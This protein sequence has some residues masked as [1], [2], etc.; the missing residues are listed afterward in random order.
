MKL[1]GWTGALA[2][3]VSLSALALFGVSERRAVANSTQA[4]Q[5]IRAERIELV[6]ARGNVR[7]RLNTE[8]D[9]EVVL[10]L[11][12]ANGEIRAKLGASDAGSA[13]VLLN[14]AT[15]PGVHI[16]ATGSETALKLIDGNQR[17]ILE[18]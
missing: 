11:I 4:A 8:P 1:S 3:L 7:A 14:G 17:R 5:V 13:L 10:R 9:G 16:L 2:M 18:P 15:E 12:G 6:D